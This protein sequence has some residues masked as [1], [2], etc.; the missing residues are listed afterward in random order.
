MN[1]WIK[2][3]LN[4]TESWKYDTRRYIQLPDTRDIRIPNPELNKKTILKQYEEYILKKKVKEMNT[5]EKS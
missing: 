5:P 2:K 4:S 3:I 1:E